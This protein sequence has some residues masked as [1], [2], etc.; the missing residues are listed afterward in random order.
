MT[1]IKVAIAGLGRVGSRFFWRLLEKDGDGVRVV[2][3][4]D[5]H[6]D[7]EIREEVSQRGIKWYR[8]AVEMVKAEPFVDIV[9]DLTGSPE[10]RRRMRETLF[11]SGNRHTIL[12]PE[13]V[14]FLIWA[15]IGE[16]L[17]LPQVHASQN[18]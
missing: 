17:A 13:I 1:E 10:T 14:A 11:T 5:R 12:A 4:A 15:F 7:P 2:A 3:V 9:F 6:P 16:E 18:Y 8:D